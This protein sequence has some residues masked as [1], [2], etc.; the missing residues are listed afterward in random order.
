MRLLL[1]LGLSA[2]ITPTAAA[3]WC[4]NHEASR[5][6]FVA[7]QR[8]N[9][10]EGAF[11]DFKATLR[12]NPDNPAAGRFDVTVRPASA[13]TGA[14]RRD[15]TLHEPAWFHT[16]AY[17]KARFTTVAI[18]ETAG[19]Y[20]YEAKG[21]LTIR[22]TTRTITLPFN[23]RIDGNQAFMDGRVTLDRTSFGVGQGQWADC[24]RVG[25]NVDVVVELQ[26]QRC[27]ASGGE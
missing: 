26:L 4:V 7:S 14:S 16:D 8:G 12:F 5:L 20:T 6:G 10:V 25:C 27:A 17:P 22:E 9:T 3:P 21:R 1:I 18:R 24:S 15:A 13:Q 2:V 23:W 19:D 11:G